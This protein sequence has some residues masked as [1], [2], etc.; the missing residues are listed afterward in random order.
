MNRASPC[1]GGDLVDGLGAALSVAAGH[2]DG[3]S[4]GGQP[5]G[6]RPADAG[7][8][9]GDQ[10][11]EGAQVEVF[12]LHSH[13]VLLA[14]S[15]SGPICPGTG[16]DARTPVGVDLASPR[17]RGLLGHDPPG[18]Y[19]LGQRPPPAGFVVHHRRSSATW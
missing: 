14:E 1:G 16:G 19:L 4:V 5:L 13:Q 3:H 9:P 10:G 12:V 11:G 7:G 18:P 17:Q 8:G 6:D 2:D 15:L